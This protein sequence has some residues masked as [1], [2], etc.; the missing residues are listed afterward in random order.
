MMLNRN[1]LGKITVMVVDDTEVN[2]KVAAMSLKECEVLEAPNGQRALELLQMHEE[3]D[4]VLLDVMMPGVS[5]YEICRQIKSHPLWRLI[6]VI[7]LTALNNV[8]DRVSALQAG[9]DDFIS[10]P[11]DLIE[12][13]A[14][15]Y[16]SAKAKRYND[17]LEE[18]KNIL[19]TLANMVENKDAYTNGHLQRIEH[20]TEEF[21]ARL[22]LSPHD[23]E[24][25]RYGGLLHDIGKVGITD[26]I[27]LKPGRLTVEEFAIMQKHSEIGFNIVNSLR[28]GKQVG[29]IVRGHHER[30]NSL[31]YPDGLKGEEIPLGARI[32]GICD[33]FDALTTPRP[34]R[35][36]I[37]HAE[38][39]KYIQNQSGVHFDPEL[40]SVFVPMI[41]EFL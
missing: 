6:P 40:V 1:G 4:V 14:R 5:G 35:Q 32:I 3:I 26:T 17:Q 29:P 34:Y 21:S 27:L 24:V 38:A 28:M 19:F 37:S 15:V 23:Q 33:V 10:K 16:N 30:W 25:V 22:G 20:L 7:M 11:Y 36:K 9:A 13:R 12:L 8:E 31:G 18:T 39:L 41:Q 2:R